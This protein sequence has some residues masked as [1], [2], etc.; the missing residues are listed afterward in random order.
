MFELL[1]EKAFSRTLVQLAVPIALQ[2][3]II[4]AL[5]LVTVAMIGQLGDTAIA[6]VGLA[7]QIFF[8]FQL[9]LYGIGSG[10]AIFIAQFWGKRDVRNVRRILGTSLGMSL[11]GAILFTL[12][13]LVWPAQALGIYTTDPAVI[14]LGSQFLQIAGLYYLPLAITTIYSVALRS[15][16]NVRVPVSVSVLA[17]T[18]GAALN[19][20]LIFGEFGLPAL[21]VPGSAIGTTIARFVEC[22]LLLILTYTAEDAAAAARLSDMLACDRAFL[23]HVL[24]T[25]VPVVMNEILWSVGT[26]AYSVVYARISTE[27]IAAVSIAGTIESMAFVPFQGLAIAAAIMIGHRIGADEEHKAFG[28]AKTFMLLTIAGGAVVGGLVFVTADLVLSFYKIAPASQLIARDVLS[29]IGAVLWVK[30]S[31]IMLI[32]G[33]LRAGGDIRFSATIDVGTLWLIGLPAAVLGAFVFGLD[34]H[35][36]Y[37]LAMSDEVC[38]FCAGLIRMISK[39]WINNIARQHA[40]AT[41]VD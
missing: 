33:V 11:V 37:L 17:L 31:N 30:V 14:A 12:I 32:V 28:Y 26:T 8:L 38:K 23:G 41:S 15:T 36:V 19:Y 3:L 34:A 22:G 4:A 1:R 2:Q 29:I 10:S 18:L 27:A 16:G 9:L 40:R 7:N 6:A 20:G 35:L 13:A 24:R 39:Q 5:G 21:G 25:S